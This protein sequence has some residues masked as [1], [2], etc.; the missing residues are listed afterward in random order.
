MRG[1]SRVERDDGGGDGDDDSWI[2]RGSPVIC[3]MFALARNDEAKS[4]I[5]YMDTESLSFWWVD[6]VLHLLSPGNHFLH[7]NAQNC[8]RMQKMPK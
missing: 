5:S 7:S 1:L 2:H 8:A 3:I 4:A 6:E